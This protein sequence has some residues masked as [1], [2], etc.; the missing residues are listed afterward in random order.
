MK[1]LIKEEVNKLCEKYNF[2][3][4]EFKESKILGILSFKLIQKE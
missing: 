2:K 1:E 3:L 4:M